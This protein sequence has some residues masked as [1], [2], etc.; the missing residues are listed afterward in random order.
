MT[1]YVGMCQGCAVGLTSG[2]TAAFAEG[3]S[4]PREGMASAVLEARA[5]HSARQEMINNPFLNE[6]LPPL[7]WSAG[8]RIWSVSISCGLDFLSGGF[9]LLDKEREQYF[10]FPFRCQ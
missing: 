7:F 2:T 3:V 10:F 5:E 8:N 6:Q 9:V 1:A 4:A